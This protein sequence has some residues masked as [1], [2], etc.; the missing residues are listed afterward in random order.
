MI[1]HFE[2][3]PTTLDRF[4]CGP[5]APYLDSLARLFS[6]Q[7]YC[8]QVAM[9]KL[10]L[11]ALLSRWLEQDQIEL[12]QLDEQRIGEFLTVQKKTLHRQRQ[13]RHTLTQLLRELRRLGV[14]PDP[15]PARMGSATDM[16]LQVYGQFLA[17]ERGLSQATLDNYL[18]VARC[19]L[20]K[21]F[22]TKP[23]K[24]DRLGGRDI[25]RFMRPAKLS[26]IPLPA[27]P[28]TG[29]AGAVSSHRGCL[30]LIGASPVSGASAGQANAGKLRS[31]LRL[32]SA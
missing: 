8:H 26:G 11:A 29:A 3:N 13:V 7:G 2:F 19:F 9:Q 5:L 12:E 20:T 14:I 15:Q 24:L 18:P 30:A 28:T 27:G 16:L 23:I 10:R 4:R 21:A 31:Q 1:H 6:E 22:G 32:W 25:N 17:Q